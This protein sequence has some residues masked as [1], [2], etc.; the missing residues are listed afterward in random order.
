MGA[1]REPTIKNEYGGQKAGLHVIVAVVAVVAGV[2]IVTVVVVD[3]AL[4]PDPRQVF[5]G[6]VDGTYFASFHV[7]DHGIT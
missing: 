1:N 4:P 3:G 7:C 6:T 2:A 5:S